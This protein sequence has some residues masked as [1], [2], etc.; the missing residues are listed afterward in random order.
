MRDIAF[1]SGLELGALLRGRQVSPVEVME[2]TLRRIEAVDPEIGA[3]ADVD[4]DRAMAAAREVADDDRRA[5]AG[6]P[7]AVKANT[8]AVGT[9]MDYGCRLLAGFRPGHDAFLVRRLRDEGF[10][11]IGSTKLPEMGILP[12]TEPLSGGPA[13]NPFDPERTPGGSSGG[14]AAAVASGMLPLAHGNDG[15]GS[16]RIPAACCGLVGLKPSRGR[17]SRGPDQGESFLT[18]DGTLTRTVMDTAAA[19]D[20]LAGYEVGDATWAARP[21]QPYAACIRREPGRLRVGVATGNPLG[22]PLHADNEAAVRGAAELL[23]SLGHE[24]LETQP[25]F[26]GPDTLGLFLTVYAANIGLGVA[27]AQML[28]GREAG[29]DDI[30]PLTRAMTERAAATTS[31]ELMAS[32]AM[33]QGLARSVIATW[34]DFDVLLLPVVADRPVPVGTIHGAL[35]PPMEG[36]ERATAFAPYAALFNITGQPAISVPWGLAPDG[37]PLAI[38]L[39]GSPLGEETLLQVAVQIEDA[40]PWTDLRPAAFAAAG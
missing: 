14:A 15:G 32:M 9:V 38:Q 7:I 22:S 4:G 2:A 12:T 28:A 31:V 39:V 37:L 10:I 34:A 33:L 40:R 20:V 18:V 27:Y 8:P 16:I 3:F 30:E 6:V 35:D 26:P 17:V 21:T 19:L 13:R 23:T 29:P 24:V 36:F 11:V 25:A 5:F 1:L